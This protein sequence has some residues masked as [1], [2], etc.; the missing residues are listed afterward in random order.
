MAT[1]LVVD[2]EPYVRHVVRATLETRHHTVCLAEDGGSAL[3]VAMNERPDLVL[4]DWM[5]PDMTGL[6]VCRGM[7][8]NPNTA[9]IPIIFLT[10]IDELDHK[11]AGLEAG[12]DDYMTKPFE[13]EELLARVNVQLRKAA[14]HNQVNPLSQLPGNIVIEKVIEERLAA[15][16]EIF[17]LL[18]FDLNDFKAYN[19]FFG[20]SW[21]D[22]LLRSLAQ[23]A[24]RAVTEHGDAA[25]FLGHVGG[26]DFVAV[27]RTEQIA[28]ICEQAIREFDA[29]AARLCAEAGAPNGFVGVDRAGQTRRFGPPSLAIGVITNEQRIFSSYLE[30]GKVAAQVKWA[31]KRQPGSSYFVDRRRS[32]DPDD[33]PDA[34]R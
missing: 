23:I 24:H 29:E 31:A 12:A 19:D 14:E 5:L 7:R 33:A 2:D 27:C 18:Y 8:A 13:P 3:V 30:L 4:L 21:G 17:A 10:A 25:S 32:T 6:A 26:D 34:E 15:P 28:A 22:Q 1:I 11:I 20:F 9:H 16:D